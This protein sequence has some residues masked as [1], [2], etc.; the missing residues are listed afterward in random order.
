[1]FRDFFGDEFSP[2]YGIPRERGEQSLGSGVI[3]SPDG[4]ILTNHHVVQEASEIEIFS[5]DQ[6]RLKGRIV[7]T[8]PKTD[9]AVVKIE[10]RSLPVLTLADSSRVQVGD[11]ALAIGNPFGVGETVTMGIVGPPAGPGSTRRTTRTSSRPTR[12]S[13]AAT[14]AARSSTP[15]AS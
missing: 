6:R 8:N 1:M 4:C 7:G 3:V 12:P 11:F 9:L 15:R 13:T 14:R 10:E 5:S 2:E